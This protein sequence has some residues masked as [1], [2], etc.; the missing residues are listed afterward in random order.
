MPPSRTEV[1]DS[2]YSTTWQTMGK[3]VVD[4]MFYHMPLLFWLE[5]KQR[6][7]KEASGRWIGRQVRLG[8]N[9]A[10]ESFGRG[11]TFSNVDLDVLTTAQYEWR[12][13]G[14]PLTR[15]WDDEKANMGKSQMIN[16]VKTNIE[17]TRDSLRELLSAQIWAETVGSKDV[18]SLLYYL[19]SDPTTNEAVAGINQVTYADW[20]N[21]YKDSDADGSA[22]VYLLKQ[23]RDLV[24]LAEKKGKIDYILAGTDAYSIYDD[25][26][27][28]QKQIMDKKMG[29]AEF[30]S[31][32]WKGIPL[33][34]DHDAPAD[35]MQFIDSRSLE[36]LTHPDAYFTWTKW[37]ELPNGLDK[38]AQLVVRAQ[39]LCT[40]RNVNARLFDIEE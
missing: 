5:K 1:F 34:L 4:Q 21:Q 24:I 23:M 20:Q 14:I 17:T 32:S 39:L 27:I 3:K 38:V 36:W 40:K 29:D 7:N 37:K 28:G 2:M 10:G 13:V 19:Q 16:L 30:A 15:Y 11:H 12:N 9:T 22:T 33:V 25:V 8:K 18:N 26:A 31:I 6:S 35:E